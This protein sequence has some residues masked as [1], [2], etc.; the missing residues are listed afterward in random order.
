MRPQHLQQPLRNRSKRPRNDCTHD[1]PFMH[2]PMLTG[3][4]FTQLPL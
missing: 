4:P 1:S 3:L 2:H